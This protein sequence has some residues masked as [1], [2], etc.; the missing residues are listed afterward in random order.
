[1]PRAAG[2][3]AK[4]CRA[5]CR[6]WQSFAMGGRG[7][8]M[9]AFVSA[10]GSAGH[11]PRNRRVVN[12]LL[13]RRSVAFSKMLGRGSRPRAGRRSCPAGSRGR[14]ERKQKR[15]KKDRTPQPV[16]GSTPPLASQQCL[17]VWSF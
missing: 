14:P 17:I 16:G 5:A 13:H 9:P 7:L 1:L 12:N 4:L 10:A 15:K 3:L 8:C 2:G 6:P 11:W